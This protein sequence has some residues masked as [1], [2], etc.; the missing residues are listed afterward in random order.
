M[1]KNLTFAGTEIYTVELAALTMFW[2][3]RPKS[4]VVENLDHL[5]ERIK[6]VGSFY[7]KG[8]PRNHPSWRRGTIQ[9]IPNSQ[10]PTPQAALGGDSTSSNAS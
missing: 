5:L 1:E 2:Q 10:A 7:E 3:Q 8:D 9:P 4:R 6:A